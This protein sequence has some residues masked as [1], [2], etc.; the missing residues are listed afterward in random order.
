MSAGMGMELFESCLSQNMSL[1]A[2]YID[3][4]GLKMINDSQ[5]HFAG[6]EY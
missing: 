5:G 6:G 1:T 4:D 3:L 2:M